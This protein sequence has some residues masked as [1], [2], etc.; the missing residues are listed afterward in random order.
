LLHAIVAFPG[1][2][3]FEARYLSGL[4]PFIVVLVAS[5]VVAISWRLAVPL[6][7]LVLVALSLV[8]FAKREGR[9]LEPDVAAAGP[10]LEHVGART[11]LT[12]SAVVV[13]YLRDWQPRL[14]RP[15]GLGTGDEEA[16]RRICP[17]PVVV[18]DDSRVGAGPRS[19]PG[20]RFVIGPIQMQLLPTH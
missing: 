20:R 12:N 13:Y 4:I 5:A 1:P 17:S 3:I 2:D 10:V 11:V 16:C 19:G 15:F 18:V 14:D 9:E 6:A 8:I 7:C